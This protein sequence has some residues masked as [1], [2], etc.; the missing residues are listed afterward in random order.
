MGYTKKIK[1]GLSKIDYTSFVGETGT[2]FY[3]EENGTLRLSD[4]LTPGGK[5]VNLIG[6]FSD[7]AIG[8]ITI[9]NTTIKPNTT[10]SDL[11]LSVGGT[12]QLNLVGPVHVHTDGDVNGVPAL[13]IRPDGQIVILVPNPDAIEGAVNIVGN[14]QGYYVNPQHSGVMLH[15]TGQQSDPSILYIDGVNERTVV[16]GRR[17][18]GTASSPSAV[19]NNQIIASYGATPYTT[20][21]WPLLTTCRIDFVA[22]E[23]Q[24]GSAQGNRIEF[25]ATPVGS[26]TPVL[27]SYYDGNGLNSINLTTSGRVTVKNTNIVGNEGLLN[28]TGNINGNY[29]QPEIAGTMLQVTGKDN[30]V[31]FITLDGYGSN[32]P[33]GMVFRTSGGT[34]ANPTTTQSGDVLG[35]LSFVGR[36]STGH[37]GTLSGALRVTATQNYTDTAKGAKMI[38]S[39]TP[40]GSNVY[41]D[42]MTLTPNSLTLTNGANVKARLRASAGT[43]NDP[44]IQIEAGP[45]PSVSSPGAISYNGTAMYAVPQD[46]ELGLITT[47]QFFV[48]D[49]VHN[50]T[51]GTTNAQSL[52]GKSV[53]ISANTRYFY[54]IKAT[55]LKNGSSSNQP[56]INYGLSLNGGATLFKHTYSV[57]SSVTTTPIQPTSTVTMYN[58]ITTGY[59]VLVPITQ[60]MPI[61]TSYSTF[62]VHGM[63]DV[64]TAGTLTPQIAFSDAP[65]TSCSV[66]PSSNIQIYPISAS[67]SDTVVG[68]WA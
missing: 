44:S 10:N 62:E 33:M 2:L 47:P 53:H 25:W 61:A 18:N 16:A 57:Y 28:I 6:D 46:G 4:G 39:L 22:N 5:P 64:N 65:N 56:T 19:L 41:I 52:F 38:F 12:G 14:A 40:D 13:D 11:T 51:A 29:A 17:Y 9:D 45:L 8:N 43:S 66:Q 20:S 31:G 1:A 58:S 60:A 30:Q 26:S 54:R 7:I 23:N 35:L 63:I 68:T 36:G 49:Q 48:I 59:G 3:N 55:I 21:G 27:Q 32:T 50:L 67:G 24:T 37:G 15:I 42:A 34:L